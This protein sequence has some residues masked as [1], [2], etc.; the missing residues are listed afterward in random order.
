MSGP[1]DVLVD[2]QSA[3]HYTKGERNLEHV[4]PIPATHSDLV[5]FERSED[6]VVK[7]KLGD[8]CR[9][10]VAHLAQHVQATEGT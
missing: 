6:T 10:A 2:K 8:M 5:K 7:A 4:L 3:T 9:R 1:K